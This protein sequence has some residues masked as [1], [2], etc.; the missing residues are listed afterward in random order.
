MSPPHTLQW[1]HHFFDCPLSYSYS[2]LTICY[3]LTLLVSTWYFVKV[4]IRVSLFT[5]QR[6]PQKV[7][8]LLTFLQAIAR[9]A[10]FILSP[11]Q[12]PCEPDGFP[13]RTL[14]MSMLGT[15]PVAFFFTAFST[16]LAAFVHS[17]HCVL[18][19]DNATHLFR[20]TVMK[21]LFVTLN[22]TVYICLI[23]C[24]SMQ[25]VD[26]TFS[27]MIHL[28]TTIVLIGV[29]LF[30]AT[31]FVT[32]GFL[33]YNAY[34][35]MMRGSA[36]GPMTNVVTR[37]RSFDPHKSP[38]MPALPDIER[39]D[40]AETAGYNYGRRGTKEIRFHHGVPYAE[41]GS[42]SYSS[43][44]SGS[45]YTAIEPPRKPINP[46]GRVVRIAMVCAASMFIRA[47][48]IPVMVIDTPIDV[49]AAVLTVYFMCGE[50]LPESLLLVIIDTGL[51]EYRGSVDTTLATQREE[52]G[53]TLSV[54]M[55]SGVT[56][57]SVVQQ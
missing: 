47:V 29:A 18:H 55:A 19:R 24:Y 5:K 16:L 31:V 28:I 14:L 57:S 43:Y 50:L 11:F 23:V 4:V 40:Y 21:V 52:R 38:D 36:A 10:Y 8:L 54:T 3:S 25:H 34:H 7:F 15:V 13:S 44:S 53:E 35:K 48:L 2:F 26:S 6:R 46:M 49:Y 37:F 33:L 27:N 22:L 20:F 41:S 9:I 56:S 32:Y 42:V 1:K 30:L 12:L 39:R 17:F 51:R 45:E